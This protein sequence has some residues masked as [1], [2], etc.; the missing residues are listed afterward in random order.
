MVVID[1]NAVHRFGRNR[2]NAFDPLC[3]AA[4]TDL[5]IGLD[6]D[7]CEN[8]LRLVSSTLSKLC[9]RSVC[10][11]T[12]ATLDFDPM[13]SGFG[14]GA[15]DSG[16]LL[17]ERER[18][19]E[20]VDAS[21]TNA[22]RGTGAALLIEGP[23]GIGKTALLR[24]A[25]ARAGAHGITVLRARGI[26][27]ESDYAFGVTRQC[28]EPPLRIADTAARERLLAG[29]ARLAA[30][31]ILDEAVEAATTSYGVLHGLFWLMFNLSQRA[32]LLL[33][34]DDV[35]W[36]DRPSLRF[37]SFLVHRL[38]SMPVAVLLALRSGDAPTGETAELA[39]LRANPFNEVL[40]PAPLAESSVSAL[41]LAAGKGAADAVFS[42]A[43]HHATGG[44]PFLLVE[45]LRS[46]QEAGIPFTAEA[47]QRVHALAPREVTRSVQARL[48]LVCSAARA[49]ARALAVL[50]DGEPLELAASLAGLDPTVSS[51]AACA[52]Q[53]IDLL[54]GGRL[55]RFRHPLLRLAVASGLTPLEREALHRRAVNLV[56][57]RG[58]PPE[59]TALH[60]L[61]SAP[62]H[63]RADIV[64]L[65][66]AAQR[67][68]E[69]GAP[70]TAVVLLG[71]ALEERMDSDERAA[72]LLELG[73][74]EIT[75]GMQAAAVKHLD[76]AARLASHPHERARA[77]T[78]LTGVG[79]LDID[80]WRELAPMLDADVGDPELRLTLETGRLLVS[81][82]L[83]ELSDE[84]TA[85]IA[86]GFARL[87]GD[88]PAECAA[89]A[90]L[91]MYRRHCGADAAEVGDLAERAMRTINA[92]VDAGVDGPG[93]YYLLDTLLS[94]DRLDAA[95]RMAERGRATSRRQGAA[96]SFTAAQSHLA[97]VGHRR[98]RL[99]EAE[100]DALTATAVRPC[101]PVWQA[102]PNI[103]L[104]GCLIDRGDL[105]A[106][107]EACVASGLDEGLPTDFFL[108]ADFYFVRMRLRA[109]QGRHSEALADF[110]EGRRLAGSADVTG[111][112][113]GEYLVAVE[114][115]RAL[116][117]SDAAAGL[118]AQTLEGAR[119]WGTPGAMG[120]AQRIRGHLADGSDAIDLLRD[121]TD[122]LERSPARLEHA[123]ALIDVGAALRRAGHRLDARQS[124]R[125]GYELAFSCGA[126]TLTE[127]ARVELNASGIRLR[128]QA[129][130]G[131]ASLTT[132]ERR[133]ADMAAA[134]ASNAE[135]AQELF[136]TVKT[137]EMHLTHAY[138]KLDISKRTQLARALTNA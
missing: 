15:A 134:D 79:H 3:S 122:L 107:N 42:K 100:A 2:C 53:S 13:V 1:G 26:E 74:N 130:S 128:R 54:D 9:N 63:D 7:P 40:M 60:I 117:D 106:A 112:Q 96:R 31:V 11:A 21:L 24:A 29:A 93:A 37:L 76:E 91:A 132:S 104:A 113:V 94:C 127:I 45:L 82:V 69:R 10:G 61:A 65:R 136:I 135:I 6:V 111:K 121:A 115:H 14:A 70:D 38:E 116:G 34:V 99:R 114:S 80:L 120:Q 77:V 43:C 4:L 123:R 16:T 81:T 101:D 66:A 33:T 44:N 83:G 78:V 20:R 138:R 71:R 68:A 64:T 55:P 75:A 19:L 125:D 98:G 86:R 129:L 47:V 133:I 87:E 30:P 25:R 50:G 56:R 48:A 57:D 92:L 49:L 58:D 119:R 72:V 17:F 131:I 27:L 51:E 105:D 137:V 110:A 88:T 109:A 126:D 118:F 67:V 23:A 35:Q 28:L 89:L 124:L 46:V 97:L 39:D 84:R 85:S 32:P 5:L 18:E 108:F 52:L 62:G 73:A 102:M 22:A 59:L 103:T 41:F 8:A 90:Q 36:A 12:G 95:Q